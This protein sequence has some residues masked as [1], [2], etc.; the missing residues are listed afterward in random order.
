[1]LTDLRTQSDTY[2]AFIDLLDNYYHGVR[3][4]EKSSVEEEAEID[5]FLDTVLDTDIM[6]EVEAF[7]RSKGLYL[8]ETSAIR[9]GQ[10]GL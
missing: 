1:M 8:C 4:R 10:Y 5:W 7:L 3:V 9:S 2:L 6:I